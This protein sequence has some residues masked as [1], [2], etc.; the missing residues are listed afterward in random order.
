M[1]RKAVVMRRMVFLW[2]RVLPVWGGNSAFI[3]SLHDVWYLKLF[4]SAIPCQNNREPLTTPYV[5]FS[6]DISTTD[7]N[8]IDIGN[9]TLSKYGQR[10]A[11]KPDNNNEN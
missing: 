7:V 11:D 1:F 6:V 8:Y 5:P 3:L 10:Y 4:S 2:I 9:Y